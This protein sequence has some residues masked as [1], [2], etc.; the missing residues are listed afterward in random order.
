MLIIGAFLV[1]ELR[2]INKDRIIAQQQASA[3]RKAQDDA[4][5]KVL[6][7]QADTLKAQASG[8]GIT[9]NGPKDCNN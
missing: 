1:T 7:A 9:A 6:S 3:D 4:F 5:S 8:F 2:A